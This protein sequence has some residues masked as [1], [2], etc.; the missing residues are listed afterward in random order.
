VLQQVAAVMARTLRS[1]DFLARFAGDEF[2]V[3]L[4]ET[5]AA[6][7]REVA[8]RVTGAVA[9]H[10]WGSIVPGTPVTLTIGLAEL[11]AGT[12]LAEAFRDAD[13]L[14]LQAKKS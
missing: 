11:G 1:G 5:D 7:A 9:A 8:A 14:M 13:L 4:T 2:V 6:T 3:V 12:P 10:N